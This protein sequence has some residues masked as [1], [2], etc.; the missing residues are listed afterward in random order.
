L[1]ESEE[2]VH[3]GPGDVIAGK[4]RVDKLV[5]RGG[6]G[7]VLAAQHLALGQTVAIKLLAIDGLD[8]ERKREAGTRFLREGQSAARLTSDHVVR[9]YDVGTLDTG[10]PFMVME[11]LR[12]EDLATL[13][14]RQGPAPVEVAVEYV[15][16][17]CD[18]VAEAHATG[19]VHR[20]LKPSNLFVSRR[21]DGRAL[22]K[23]LD[24]GISKA[25]VPGSDAFEGNLTTTRSV[26]GSPYYMSPEQVRD[27]KR[28][29]ART[30]IW[31][32]GMIL[33]ELMTGEPAFNADTLP[34]I[35]AAIAADTPTPIRTQRSDV[36][37][38]VEAIVLRCLEKDPAKRF[39]NI[40][41]LVKA[42]APFVP[43]TPASSSLYASRQVRAIDD[44]DHLKFSPTAATIGLGPESGPRRSDDAAFAPTDQSDAA[45]NTMA[46]K[47][48]VPETPPGSAS[49]A[50]ARLRELRRQEERTA[51]LVSPSGRTVS[52]PGSRARHAMVVG[53]VLIVLAGAAVVLLR[54]GPPP[55]PVTSSVPAPVDRFTMTIDSMPSGAHVFNGE[56]I[57]G[58]TPFTTVLDNKTVSASPRKLTLRLDGYEP[59]D[60]VQGPSENAVR[61]SAKLVP[62]REAAGVA[63][64]PPP[65]S[66]ASGVPSRQKKPPQQKAV[67][68]RPSATP[69]A[70]SDIRLER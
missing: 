22:V 36:P 48:G 68:Q 51:T 37:P 67:P 70:P 15:V 55:A 19:I 40:P 52:S 63:S 53:A 18:A 69:A 50:D 21:S 25:I 13:L 43:Q 12:G 17:A 60:I 10:A 66:G 30:D 38:E 23:V 65:A 14:E 29:D 4:Y 27:A 47:P 5:G 11:L 28:V 32:L 46:S 49:A 57:I 7:V 1:P 64:E 16:Q 24:F 39:Q 8:E 44:L 2:T 56:Q 26:V 42:L 41:E 3:P 31:S 35:C 6:M 61:A 54:P 34:G 9:I 59:F 45:P 62:V 58:T 33:Y 20:D